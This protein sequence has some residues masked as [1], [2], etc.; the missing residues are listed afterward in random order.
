[1]SAQSDALDKLL[2][3]TPEMQSA[4]GVALPV[5]GIMGDSQ[6]YGQALA[7][8]NRGS[9]LQGV[10]QEHTAA[11]G[12]HSPFAKVLGFFGHALSEVT[13]PVGEALGAGLHYAGAPLREVQHQYRYIHDVWDRY[14]PID[15]IAELL[16]AAGI[17]GLAAFTDVITAGAASP[18]TTL[19]AEGATGLEAR[20]IHP[21]SWKRTTD[22]EAYLDKGGGHVSP[23]RDVGKLLDYIPG[24]NSQ[25]GKHGEGWIAGTIDAIADLRADPLAQLG[26]LRGQA[27]SLEGAGGA[28]RAATEAEKAAGAGAEVP[29]GL[30]KIWG[31]LGVRNV[32]QAYL[33]YGRFKNAVKDLAT[34]SDEGQ[35]VRKYGENLGPIADRLAAA[36]SPS[37]VM[38]VF[39]GVAN[40]NEMLS[41]RLPTR[42]FTR[43]PFSAMYNAMADPTG[44]A[45][46]KVVA[47]SVRL[48]NVFTPEDLAFSS[49]S[50]DPSE[51]GIRFAAHGVYKSLLMGMKP[52]EAQDVVTELYRAGTQ[53]ARDDILNNAWMKMFDNMGIKELEIKNAEGVVEKIPL[54]EASNEL[55]RQKLFSKIEDTTGNRGG[56]PPLARDASGRNASGFRLPDGSIENVPT[57]VGTVNPETGEI[58]LHQDVARRAFPDVQKMRHELAGPSRLKVFNGGVGE[59]WYE[60]YTAGVFKPLALNTLG[61]AFRVAGG[62][63]IPQAMR[64]ETLNLLKSRMAASLGKD[65]IA[66]AD[67][68]APH[69]FAAWYKAAREHIVQAIQTGSPDAAA[70]AEF[71]GHIIQDN[72]GHVMNPANASGHDVAAASGDDLRFSNAI[73]QMHRS[74]PPSQMGGKPLGEFEGRDINE[75]YQW[76]HN[77]ERHAA[78]DPTKLAAQTIIDELTPALSERTRVLENAGGV[79]TEGEGAGGFKFRSE[80]DREMVAADHEKLAEKQR[81]ALKSLTEE[82]G[83]SGPATPAQIQ[84]ARDALAETEGKLRDIRG[85]KLAGPSTSRPEDFS[86]VALGD[87][88]P[89]MEVQPFGGRGVQ[90]GVGDRVRPWQEGDSPKTIKSV[91][92]LSGSDLKDPLYRSKL[93]EEGWTAAEIDAHIGERMIWLE[94]EDGT[95]S[96]HVP[97]STQVQAATPKPALPEAWQPK[98]AAPVPP[99]EGIHEDAQKLSDALQAKGVPWKEANKYSPEQWAAL[100]QEAG[101]APP[102]NTMIR[103]VRKSLQHVEATR[104]A[105][106]GVEAAPEAVRLKSGHYELDTPEGKVVIKRVRPRGE[107]SEWHVT[108]PGAAPEA[109]VPTPEAPAVPAAPIVTGE[110]KWETTKG[111]KPGDKIGY[112]ERGRAGPKDT[113]TTW[114]TIKSVDSSG[115]WKSIT[116]EDG[117]KTSGGSATRMHIQRAE[118]AAAPKAV[119]TPEVSVS[120]VKPEVYATL[121][122]A[123]AAAA[124]QAATPAQVGL[125]DQIV[126]EAKG[127]SDAEDAALRSPGI[128][129]SNGVSQGLAEKLAE[130]RGIDVEEARNVLSSRP[131]GVAPGEAAPSAVAAPLEEHKPIKFGRAKSGQYGF[132]SYP[133]QGGVIGQ[134][135]IEKV[136]KQWNVTYPGEAEVGSTHKT[137]KEAQAAVQDFAKT[138]HGTEMGRRA[139]NIAADIPFDKAKKAAEEKVA[140]WLDQAPEELLEHNPR[141]L[142]SNTEGLTP[143]QEWAKVIVKTMLADVTKPGMIDAPIADAMH[144]DI[145][146][147]IANGTT[148][149]LDKLASVA[150]EHRPDTL[151]GPAHRMPIKQSTVQRVA[152]WGHTKV[153][154]PMIDYASR[155][156]MYHNLAWKEYNGGLKAAVDEGLMAPHEARMIAQQR[157]SFNMSKLVHNLSERTYLSE[158]TRNWAPFFFA[159]T[160]SWRRMGQLLVDDPGAFRRFQLASSMLSDIGNPQKGEDGSSHLVFPG[161]GFLA[162]GAMALANKLGIPMA[163]AIPVAF[164]GTVQSLGPVFPLADVQMPSGP[165]VSFA[166]KALATMFPELTPVG[167]HIVGSAGMQQSFMDMIIPNSTLRGLYHTFTGDHNRAF[168]N[169]QL[170]VIQ[171]MAR[172]QQAEE[173]SA[174]KEGREAKHIIPADDAS[175]ID[176]QEFMNKVKNQTRIVMGVRAILATFNPTATN[177]EIGKSQLRDEVRADIKKMGMAQ[178]LQEFL[179]RH[180]DASPYTVFT[181]EA[182]VQAPLSASSEVGTW[183]QGNLDTLKGF[184]YGGAWLIPQAKNNFDQGVYNEQLAM[185]LRQRKA[186]DQFFKDI[187]IAS[188]NNQYY[189]LKDQYDAAVKAVGGD[190]VKKAAID[191][192]WSAMKA[193][194][195]AQN[196][197]WF[198]DFQSPERRIMRDNTIADFRRMLGTPG[199]VPPSPQLDGIRELMTSYDQFVEASMPG[200]QDYMAT[201]ARASA[202]RR[203][204]TYLDGLRKTRPELEPLILKIFKGATVQAARTAQQAADIAPELQDLLNSLTPEQLAGRTP[205][206]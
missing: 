203:W 13:H 134:G 55:V 81:K 194:F 169:A 100:A 180:P 84:K 195:G 96:H 156:P 73:D 192:K 10:V 49:K 133:E 4:P 145:L 179:T 52:Q 92:D 35:I 63:I 41:G 34:I 17:M 48:P 33:R 16:P 130:M 36:D 95:L 80:A 31:G 117:G 30:G 50:F 115:G 6:Q 18:V 157:A 204:D 51:K 43:V 87:L 97:A 167:E 197:V 112:T 67:D 152:N 148:S 77:I 188:S 135:K 70:R 171:D 56:G 187:Q 75:V 7:Q 69:F 196:P 147:D 150:A 146:Q 71:S 53:G 132:E 190:K 109:P 200:R 175:A 198:E 153:F 46:Q 164:T 142:H 101:V 103:D 68:E 74:T 24:L 113:P 176:K 138:A 124:G 12:G 14:G 59:W 26:H 182:N 20:L 177:A 93:L 128:N 178:G 90:S 58:A 54:D 161:E 25:T 163:G 94:F 111:L 183:L 131:S 72:G 166:V 119:P 110:A 140:Q 32:E 184:A 144:L 116:L 114:R 174:A 155:E 121:D 136:G 123:K 5:S 86:T 66:L 158:G 154:S 11:V 205:G 27:L 44:N 201:V 79:G 105:S 139:S 15:A 126:S 165:M 78:D 21:D 22:G 106:S 185:S 149:D 85:S 1:M 88:K 129:F 47:K 2:S 202:E 98:P 28:W 137:L 122:E 125:R 8:V 65:G 82:E 189:A 159:E 38:D 64:G 143:H 127:L 99:L 181:S 193:S 173:L 170:Y 76:Q 118:T 61:F 37:G 3:T 104:A 29:V 102:A 160:Q 172:Q 83:D 9:T 168:M 162:Q 42:S 120:T 57:H 45:L 206:G 151:V 89:G 23:G 199:A 40:S 19:L 108:R 91:L 62:E 60:H 39:R 107:A 191:R 141:H 186:P